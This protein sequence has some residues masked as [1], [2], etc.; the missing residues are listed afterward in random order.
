MSAPSL[1]PLWQR[2]LDPVTKLVALAYAEQ[3]DLDGWIPQPDLALVVAMTGLSLHAVQ[4]LTRQLVQRG[5]LVAGRLD[6]ADPR[7]RGATASP[8]RGGEAMAEAHACTY[9]T[10]IAGPGDVYNRLPD[11]YVAMPPTRRLGGTARIILLV[12]RKEY[13]CPLP[14]CTTADLFRIAHRYAGTQERTIHQAIALLVRRGYLHP[15]PTQEG[16]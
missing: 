6:D 7:R 2:D 10:V 1:T 14:F 8:P 4:A 9:L 12:L 3:A 16:R 13:A 11:D 5:V 15:L